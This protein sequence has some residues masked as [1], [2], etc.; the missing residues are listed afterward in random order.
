MEPKAQSPASLWPL[1]P[2][3]GTAM[4]GWTLDKDNAFRLADRFYG[5]GG[6]Q[7]DTASNYPIDKDPEHFG[8]AARWLA[9]WL[10]MRGAEEAEVI[11]KVGALTNDGGPQNDLSPAFLADA[12]DDCRALFGPALATFSLHWDDREDRD[13]IAETVE[14]FGAAREGELAIGLSGIARPDLYHALAP[15]LAAHWRIQIKHNPLTREAYGHYRPFRGHRR[16]IAYGLNGGGLRFG[17][18]YAAGDS[19]TVRGIAKDVDL[20]PFER[21]IEDHRA[22]AECPRTFNEL[23]I[24]NAAA[25]DDMEAILIGPS[26]PA[27]LEE[28]FAYLSGLADFLESPDGAAMVGE[29]SRSSRKPPRRSANRG[30]K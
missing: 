17:G 14:V 28:T 29:L 2:I 8:L 30:G 1:E 20:G 3:L 9:E 10:E 21:F 23:A 27:Q 11:V 25:N 26:K 7:F 13:A 5:A 4:W 15:D 16:F 12:L 18:H 22:T 19:A 24:L 6:R